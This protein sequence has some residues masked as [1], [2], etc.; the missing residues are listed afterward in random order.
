[1]QKSSAANQRLNRVNSIL[2]SQPEPAARSPFFDISEKYG[3]QVEF[4]PFI[5]VEGIS[6]KE[7]RKQKVYLED[8]TS[9]IFTSKNA[10]DN[11]FRLVDELRVKVNQDAKYFCFTPTIANY[12]Q[13]YIIYRKR[14]VFAG[15]KQIQ[16]LRPQLM[17]HRKNEKFL[18]PCSNL[19]KLEVCDYLQKMDVNFQ[20]ALMYRTVSSDL[21]DLEEITYD[22]LVFYS[23]LGI[24]SLFENFPGFNQNQTRIAI[25]GTQTL[26]AAEEAKLVVN[27]MAP[28]PE[29]PSMTMAI[30]NYLEISNK[31]A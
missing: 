18:L 9:V 17:K 6:A 3:V 4:R 16:D 14:K 1:M 30:E 29:V 2:I 5:H 7:F 27:V 19:G 24:K 13:K 8:Y 12:L 15:K 26:K 22:M 31:E 10:V 21:S 25:F 23:P 11:Y 20:E 28:Q